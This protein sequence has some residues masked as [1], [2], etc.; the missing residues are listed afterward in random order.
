MSATEQKKSYAVIKNFKGLN[1]KANR[2]AI[3]ESEFAWIENAMPIGFGNIKIIP[4]QSYVKDSSNNAITFSSTVSYLTSCN[5][6][7]NDYIVASESNGGMEY[8][9]VN[10]STKGTIAASNTFSASGVSAAQFKNE[11]IVIADPD[12]G[13]YSWDG[14]NVVSIGSVG[15]IAV[16]NAGSGY[17]YPPTVTISAPNDANGIQ[18]TA[19]ATISVSAGGVQAI[20]ITNDGTSYAQV[21]TVTIGAPNLPN[22]TQARAVASISGGK[23]FSIQITDPGSGY[24]S[25]PSVSFTS[26]SGSGAAATAVLAAGVVSSVAITNAGSG[27]TSPPTITFSGGGGSSAAAVAE[28]VTFKTGTVHILVTNGGNGYV[29]PVSVYI[30]SV[31]S[32]AWAATTAVTLGQMLS[33]SGRYYMVTV[34]GTTGASGPTHTSGT[35]TNGTATLKYVTVTDGGGTGATGQVVVSGGAITNIATVNAGSGYTSAP[36]VNIGDAGTGATAIAVV[37]TDQ[38]VDVATFAGRVWVAYG[39]TVAYSAADSYS[40]FTSVSAGSFTISDSTL[41]G[42]I[43]ALLSSNNFLYVFG[44]DSINVFSDVRVS[45]V[46]ETVFANANISASVGTRRIYAIFPYFR[47]VLFMNDYGIYALVGS[48]TNKIS[49]QLDGIFPYIDFTQPVSGG[50]VLLNNILCAVFSFTYNDPTT[51]TARPIQAVFFEKKWFITSQGNISYLTS[52]PYNGSVSLYANTTNNL[53]K[54]YS[55]SSANITSTIKTAL[56]PLGDNIRTKQAL[57]FGVEATISY[58]TDLTATM[59]SEQGKSPSYSIGSK[60]STTW[61]TTSGQ[62][63]TWVANTGATSNWINSGYTLYKSDAQKYGKYLGL[64]MTSTAPNF[65]VHTFEFEYELRVRF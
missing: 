40:D 37:N 1:T 14:N 65:T 20:N 28:L 46:G 56:M 8:F 43:K 16:S 36:S 30:G 62:V 13:L 33:Y 5:I 38:I 39:R 29:S 64:T 35:A 3:D 22:G 25:V 54:L 19:V 47:S 59:D 61:L 27:Y 23:I 48:T 55:D 58:A 57:K 18:A 52:V 24:T 6:G 44:E 53:Y 26:L 51:G 2:T 42:K 34:A 31:G 41:H 4:A 32:V 45:S 7:L 12:K 49:D 21:P 10:T 9:N 15:L 50:Q 11:R 17:T 63:S 60:N